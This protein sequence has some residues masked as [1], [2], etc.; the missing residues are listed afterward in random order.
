MERA[1]DTDVLIAGAGP[2]GLTT[3]LVLLRAGVR[4]ITVIDKRPVRVQVG[5]AAGIQ[6]RTQE[7]L[8]TLGLY[9][10]FSL[11]SGGFED[12]A[13]WVA[14]GDGGLERSIV[15]HEV[16]NETPHKQVMV[17][18]QGRGEEIF[19]AALNKCDVYIQRP[20][21]VLDYEYV[22]DAE[23]PI[24]AYV[25][26]INRG[27]V[28]RIRC[29]YL[30]SADGANSHT[31]DLSG[32]KSTVHETDDTWLV[33]DAVVDTDLPDFRRRCAIRTT[34]G[35][36]ML[37]PSPHNT[38]R[39]YLLLRD[40]KDFADLEASK[41]DGPRRSSKE[42]HGRTTLLDIV[43]RRVPPILHPYTLS[44]KH[45]EWISKYIIAQRV[46][47]N[48]TDGKNVLFVGDACH[49]HSPKAGQGMN[50]GI[51]DAVNLA[52]KLAA[53]L[54]GRAHPRLLETYNAE[55]SHIAHQ[56]IDFDTQFAQLF[57][58]QSKLHS[59]EFQ[60]LWKKSQGF[61]SG[62]DQQYPPNS[63][64]IG[65]ISNAS[66]RSTALVPLTP[67]KRILPMNLI[68]HIDGT[69]VSSLD[70]MP[71]NG[72]M[73]LVVFAGDIIREA[74]KAEFGHL[75]CSLTADDSPLTLYNGRPPQDSQNEHEKG[76]SCE[77]TLQNSDRHLSSNKLV[78]LYVVHTSDTL[79]VDLRPDFETWKYNFFLDSEGIEHLRH[80]ID[81]DGPM[82]AALVRCDGI[83]SFVR[84]A[85]EQLAEYLHR[86]LE[87]AGFLKHTEREAQSI[88]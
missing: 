3:S 2:S 84:T 82:Q 28:D 41:F 65:D 69:S 25:K 55:R 16:T 66:I 39:I 57:G 29:K 33:T 32:I 12:T 59:S 52:W 45:V 26:D 21:E 36:L 10:D 30:V 44:I 76:W 86:F 63:L 35:N 24:C 87:E 5:H 72:E 4:N 48:F 74:R 14:T 20:F 37:I 18:H 73:Y 71:L 75:Y 79:Q 22:K 64:V 11:D 88:E 80:G 68:Q 43:Q 58:D 34:R 83:I 54:R 67:G 19:N 46:I 62:L 47:E 49:S 8:R 53:V 6:P 77:D 60:E 70:T 27:L 31:R 38:I 7:I 40:K 23:Y 1:K 85:D 81:V 13:F 56:L 17:Q 51:S 61:T 42:N 50:V 15:A 78:N 9:H